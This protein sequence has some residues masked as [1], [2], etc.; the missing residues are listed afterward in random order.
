MK[1]YETHYDE[2][3]NE[4]EK[5][6]LHPELENLKIQPD[7]NNFDNMILYGPSGAGKYTQLLK[8]LKK[9]SNLKYEKKIKV[10]TDKLSYSYK[11]SDIH[12]E[13]DMSLLGCNSKILW[14]EIFQQITDII[15]VKSEKRGIIVCKNFH[16]IHNE[17]LEIFYSYIQHCSIPFN[18]IKIKFILITEH[19][20]FI[21][22]N[23]LNSCKIVSIKRPSREQY[24]NICK[25]VKKKQ[26]EK[27]TTDTP[28]IGSPSS[29]NLLIERQEYEKKWED[30]IN[31]IE[32]E[33]I[34]NC[35]EL[36]T[37]INLKEDK[38]PVNMFDTI[39][40]NIINEMNNIEQSVF[41]NF[42]D[43]LYDILIY[44]IDVNEYLWNIFTHFI[45]NKS[46][47]EKSISII[48]SKMYVFL[49]YYNNNYRPI[50]HL[51]SIFFEIVSHIKGYN[52]DM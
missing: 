26:I 15:A 22:N 51:E 45:K 17:L 13:I 14:N 44:N 42:R 6:N 25:N 33:S 19:I 3:L 27:K 36:K 49:K 1:F 38:F 9:L 31:N 5:Y 8:I 23:I 47:K 11:I 20:S 16:L 50:Y 7:F 48:L 21:P 40:K 41:T 12:Y 29:Q 35:K 4:C 24:I 52:V 46:L 37:L 39:C 34:S 32:I 43:I 2:Y 28:D 10:Q 18:N 30:I